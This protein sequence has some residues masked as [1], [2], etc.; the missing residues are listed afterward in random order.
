MT[1]HH[2]MPPGKSPFCQ[3]RFHDEVQRW[4]QCR[5]TPE[6][7]ARYSKYMALIQEAATEAA[8]Q[9]ELQEQQLLGTA[10]STGSSAALTTRSRRTPRWSAL[11][12]PSTPAQLETAARRARQASAPPALHGGIGASALRAAAARP[13]SAAPASWLHSATVAAAAAGRRAGEQ[14]EEQRPVSAAAAAAGTSA[15][16]GSGA[17]LSLPLQKITGVSGAAV[18]AQPESPLLS[19]AQVSARAAAAVAAP[20]APKMGTIDITTSVASYGLKDLYPD[21]WANTLPICRPE[22]APNKNFVSDW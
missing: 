1:K 2:Q 20:P 6:E 13:A 14:Q 18:D 9:Q 8:C 21:M 16:A 15:P 3:Q 5:A 10:R 4:L 17:A 19:P 11:P 22:A 12:D 7:R